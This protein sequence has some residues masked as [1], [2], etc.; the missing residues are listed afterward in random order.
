MGSKANGSNKKIA[1]EWAIIGREQMLAQWQ[2]ISWNSLGEIEAIT[3]I[4]LAEK[5]LRKQA[6]GKLALPGFVN[7]HA[8]LE[9]STGQAITIETDETMGDWLLKV[10]QASQQTIETPALLIAKGIEEALVSGTTTIAST[11]RGFSAAFQALKNT[12]PIRSIW[13]LEWFHPSSEVSVSKLQSLQKLLSDAQLQ[14]SRFSTDTR[15]R[16]GIGISPHSP[17]NV[18]LQA[19][20][21]LQKALLAD[22]N[23]P[24]LLWQS[25]LLETA[26]EVA[27]YQKQPEDT[28][29]SAT[30]LMVDSH[31]RRGGFETLP[32]TDLNEKN[33]PN[34]IDTVHQTLL[35]CTFQPNLPIP[36]DIVASMRAFDLLNPMLSVV[37]GLELSS[38]QAEI[39]TEAGVS[40]VTCPRSNHF[41]HGKMIDWVILSTPQ[42][43]VAIGTDAHV[44]L[45]VPVMLDIR[46]ELQALKDQSPQ[47]LTWTQLLVMATLNG[48]KALEMKGKIGELT[49]GAWADIV[50]WQVPKLFN[51]SADSKESLLETALKQKA[52]PLQVFISGILS[53]Y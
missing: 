11:V 17:Y 19:W 27:Y 15:A 44:S 23:T 47:Q 45:P 4:P 14:F 18:S 41:L 36:P 6:I 26:E 33:N 43:N 53:N 5:A 37:H 24:P 3:P 22:D 30:S 1:V 12:P 10:V 51:G 38:Q 16:T 42:L 2:L 20:Q 39:L 21:A 13:W 31:T 8:H 32:L 48:A 40:L 35:G 7:A 46:L 9:L 25:H 52:K 28:A 34:S 49:V 50:V 29:H